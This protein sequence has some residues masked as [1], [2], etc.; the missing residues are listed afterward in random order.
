MRRE[1]INNNWD[2]PF[3]F[4]LKKVLPVMGIATREPLSPLL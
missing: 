1:E 3:N 2:A 4:R